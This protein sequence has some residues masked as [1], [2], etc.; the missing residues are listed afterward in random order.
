MSSSDQIQ[1]ILFDE[2]DVRGALVGLEEAYAEVLARADYPER[3]E[4]VLGEL[5]AAVVLL[6]SNLKIEGRV[7]LQAQGEGS[8]RILMAECTHD[9]HVRGIARVEEGPLP[10]DE[11][12]DRLLVNG[13]MALTIEPNSGQRY[14]GVVPL[15]GASVSECLERYFSQSEQLPTKIQLAADGKR[16]AGMLTQVLPAAGSGA[17][18]WEHIVALAQTLKT[19]ELLDLDNETILYRLYHEERVRLFEPDPLI[20][21]CE[22]SRERSA[23]AMQM[24]TEEELLEVAEEHGG[25]LEMSCQFC[26]E[27]YRF[28]SADIQALFRNDGHLND[29]SSLH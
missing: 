9:N 1:R 4:V 8:V 26:N 16:A 15:E 28:D 6:T 29:D 14:Q 20:F 7:S 27:V 18:D 13:R 25:Q 21:K 17:A 11:R 5:L 10:D 24:M 23:N 19:D 12:F 22:C 3:L 2:I